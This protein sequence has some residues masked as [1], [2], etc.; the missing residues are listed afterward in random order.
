MT[1]ARIAAQPPIQPTYGPNDFVVQV[2]DV[3]QSGATL[4]SSRY[5]YAAKNIGRKPAMMTTAI[6][7][8]ASATRMPM[9]AVSA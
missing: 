7:S 6:L 9:V 2:N 4:L 5:A 8:L 3:P 1:V